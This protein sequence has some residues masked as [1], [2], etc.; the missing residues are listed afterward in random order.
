[1]TDIKRDML[2]RMNWIQKIEIIITKKEIR[3]NVMKNE[4]LKWLKDLKEVFKEILERELLPYRDEVDHEIII[5]T[6]KI[7]PSL[8]ISIRSKEQK[9]VKEYLDEMT[10]KE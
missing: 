6:K 3:F 5:K 2:V 10:K 4:I 9:I 7:R 8:L 1:M